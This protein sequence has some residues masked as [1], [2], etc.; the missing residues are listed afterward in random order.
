MP[1]VQ[2]AREAGR[3]STCTN[4]LRQI[5]LAMHGYEGQ[6][7]KLPGWRNGLTGGLVVSWPTV[8]LPN[9]ERKDIFNKW[10]DSASQ[11]PDDWKPAI[12]AFMCPTSPLALEEMPYDH[13]QKQ[14]LHHPDVPKKDTDKSHLVD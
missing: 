2:N 10:N 13:Q 8:I 1:A 4:N 12:S 14:H 6:K 9:L 11:P 7:S 5:G 3:R